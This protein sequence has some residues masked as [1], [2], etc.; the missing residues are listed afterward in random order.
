MRTRRIDWRTCGPRDDLGCTRRLLAVDRRDMLVVNVGLHHNEPQTSLRANVEGFLCC[1]QTVGRV[2]CIMW[3]KMISTHF[4]TEDGHSSVDP[5]R[6][7]GFSCGR[8]I[9]LYNLFREAFASVVSGGLTRQK[10]NDV[11]NP[12]IELADALILHVFRTSAVLHTVHVECDQPYIPRLHCVHHQL[13]PSPEY[14]FALHLLMLALL[15]T[16]GIGLS[17]TDLASDSSV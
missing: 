11:S 12:F 9:I 6:R 14:Q 16:C 3:R 15:Q 7:H 4:D 8:S 13:F 1:E 10:L 5:N 17:R 2:P